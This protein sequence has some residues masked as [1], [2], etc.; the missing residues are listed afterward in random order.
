[1]LPVVDCRDAYLYVQKDGDREKTGIDDYTMRPAKEF[2]TGFIEI[3]N[4]KADL[5]PLRSASAKERS[6]PKASNFRFEADITADRDLKPVFALLTFVSEGSVGTWFIPIG[7]LEQSTLKHVVVAFH[8]RVDSVGRLHVFVEGAELKSSQVRQAYDVRAY[9]SSLVQKAGPS[10]L[11]LLK[12]NESFPYV[13][14]NDGRLLAALRDRDTYYAIVVYDLD[15]KKVLCEIKT[16]DHETTISRLTWVSDHELVYLSASGWVWNYGW[17]RQRSE[18]MLLDV[19]SGRTRKL[20]DKVSQIVMSLH[21][22]PET[23]VLAQSGSFYKY[24][25]RTGRSWD[26]ENPDGGE[27]IFDEQGNT[28]IHFRVDGVHEDFQFR[29]RAKAPWEEMDSHVK[30]PGLRFNF[31]AKDAL[32]RVADILAI[33]PDGDTLYLSSRLNRDVYELDAFSMSEGVIKKTIAANPK[34]DLSDTDFGLTRLLFRKHSGEL[35][36]MIYQGERPEVIWLDAKFKEVQ[37]ALDAAFPDHVNLPL[38]WSN[39]GGTFIYFSMSDRDPGTYYIFRPAQGMLAPLLS[40]GERL[41]G[42]NLAATE[43]FDFQ[44]R[45]GA[46]VHAYIT[47]PSAASGPVPLVVDIHGGPMVR[48]TWGFDAERQFLA[49]RGYAVLQVNYRGSSGFGAKYQAAGLKARLDTV[50]IDDVADG[51]RHVIQQGRVDPARVAVMGGS[52]GGWAT[53]MCL[54]RY[55]ELYRA[56][57]VTCGVAHWRNFLKKDRWQ[58]SR[59]YSYVFWRALLEG[60]DFKNDEPII[61]P[62]LRAGEIKQ[63]IYILQ[64]GNDPVVDADEAQMMAKRL[65]STNP[66]VEFL[67]FPNAGHSE[68]QWSFTDKVRRLNET[69]SFLD[70]Q[71]KAGAAPSA[72]SAKSPGAASAPAATG[73]VSAH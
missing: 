41:K 21:E 37:H 9:Y 67:L 68:S 72:D 40:L 47:Y 70:R 4:V 1:M 35:L 39:D 8:D 63:P 64:G 24:D 54:I 10:A 16:E 62:Y 49:A 48:D 52:F 23:L 50:V 45:D 25:I 46:A 51:T 42:R 7:R 20:D 30:T 14:S 56:G 60:Q 28:R 12:L 11:E 3:S 73:P 22:H 19:R 6:D 58:D 27:F 59:E 53:Y 44:A 32:E 29:P 61:D 13:L 55:P 18:L 2:G 31:G 71:L 69:A 33:S 66:Q 43:A 15:G 5:D 34:Y 17:Y 26:L 65:Q 36:G 57:V 38:D